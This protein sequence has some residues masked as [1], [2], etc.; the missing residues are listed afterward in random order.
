MAPRESSLNIARSFACAFV[1]TLFRAQSE[2][3]P[4]DSP[5]ST[6]CFFL[7]LL[8]LRGDPLSPIHVNSDAVAHL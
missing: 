8:M 4:G 7:W 5:L 1:E 6:D 3:G 2:D